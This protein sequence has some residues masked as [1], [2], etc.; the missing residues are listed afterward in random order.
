MEALAIQHIGSAGTRMDLAM[1]MLEKVGLRPQHFYRYPHEFSG[2]QRQR[3][4]LA[5]ALILDPS[6]V[7][8]DEPVSAL[9]VSVQSQIINLLLDL[10]KD[11]D[12]TYLFISHDM[13]V[14]KY[15]SVRVAVMYLGHIVEEAA[16]DELF[17]MA[18][19]PYSQALLSSVP[20][21]N[22]KI[23]K[24]RI[25]LEGEIPSPIHAPQGCVFHT[26]CMYSMPI[27]SQQAPEMKEISCGHCVACHL[28]DK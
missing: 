15:V 25:V 23:K 27:C 12:V 6:F 4:G 9:D 11:G 21:S 10:Q 26:R 28:F 24:D 7:V 22:P 13:S 5:R 18:A 1:S 20:S 17:S 3:V 14:V 2:G 16:T 8:C 19:H